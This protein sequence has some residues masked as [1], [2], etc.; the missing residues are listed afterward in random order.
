MEGEV[1]FTDNPKK[2]Y[3][4]LESEAKD[5]LKYHHKKARQWVIFRL[6]TFLALLVGV[7]LA[8]LQGIIFVPLVLLLIVVFLFFVRRSVENKEKIAYY[9]QLIWINEAELKALAGDYSC[10]N[11]GEEYIDPSHA[12]SY[13][14]DLFGVKS[15]FQ[16]FNRTVSVEGEKQLAK[17]LLNG[18][19]NFTEEHAAI[20]EL[21]KHPK[22][23]QAF[24]ASRIELEK[25][26]N[27]TPLLLS[28]WAEKAVISLKGIK[29]G[30]VFTLIFAWG[31]SAAYYFDFIPGAYLILCWIFAL[32]PIRQRLKQTN[33]LQKKLNDVQA[34]F[35]SMMKQ[36]FVFSEVDFES[37]KLKKAQERFFKSD[38]NAEK[39]LVEFKKLCK[40]FE[41]RNNI[42][43]A[44]LLNLFM[45][46]DFRITNRACQWLNTY[47]DD[48]SS[49]EATLFEL[50]GLI[51]S[52]NFRFNHFSIT[53]YATL[54]STDKPKIKIKALGHPLI[55][56]DQLV[57]NDY[58]MEDHQFF[59]IITGPNMAGKSTFLR[60]VGINLMLAKAGCPVLAKEFLFPNYNLYTS[61]RTSDDLTEESSYFHAELT[62][63]RFIVDAIERGEKVFI[64]L[65]EILKGTNSKDKEEGSMRFLSKLLKLEARGI[66]ATHDLKLTSLA[67]ENKGFNNKYFDTQI[68]GDEIHFDYTICEGVAKNMNAS[69][70]LQKMGLVENN[71]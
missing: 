49:W 3:H 67:E 32:L 27:K 10:F 29:L 39:A 70:L 44:I 68:T 53:S 17:R 52:A 45:A 60:S 23:T 9:K 41:Y 36:T 5:K 57:Y 56:S 61:M 26:N 33:T 42:L 18:I 16:F 63:L 37:D 12:F 6:A 8:Y 4:S 24:R 14:M 58:E 34:A 25:E 11:N 31:G 38:K 48:I 66:I 1:P 51:S 21:I 62:R 65:D 54:T 35:Q 7:Y 20:E 64:I 15:F 50:E 28:Q 71:N 40:E 47:K 2:M 55:Q 13:D 69:F 46:W 30:A 59:T 19:E 43:V 22:W